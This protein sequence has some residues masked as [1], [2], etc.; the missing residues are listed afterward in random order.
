MGN[1][2][3]V[4]QT[5]VKVITNPVNQS[6]RQMIS[7]AQPGISFGQATSVV[8]Q[9]TRAFVLDNNAVSED[10]AVKVVTIGAPKNR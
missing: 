2:Y 1:I 9:A 6:Q 4:D 10:E 5:G 8:V 7:L 3:V